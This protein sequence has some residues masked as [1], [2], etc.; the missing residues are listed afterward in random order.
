MKAYGKP[1]D[2][3][4]NYYPG[5]QALGGKTIYWPALTPLPGYST[6]L[7]IS[8]SSSGKITETFDAPFACNHGDMGGPASVV[9]DTVEGYGRPVRR[10]AM[11]GLIEGGNE[12]PLGTDI[13]QF[14]A[15]PT[16]DFIIANMIVE[17]PPLI[18]LIARVAARLGCPRRG[19]A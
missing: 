18:V 7:Y 19:G 6:N 5:G 10:T 12:A 16:R 2:Y 8:S 13:L 4:G 15:A 11:L 1:V 9:D 3:N 17:T 14:I